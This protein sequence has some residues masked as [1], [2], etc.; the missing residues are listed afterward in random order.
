MCL[1][2]KIFWPKIE[3]SANANVK[4]TFSIAKF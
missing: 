1:G 4:L 3:I 2:Y